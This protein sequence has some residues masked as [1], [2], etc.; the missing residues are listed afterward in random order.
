VIILV[1]AMLIAVP[2]FGTTTYLDDNTSYEVGLDIMSS[3]TPGTESFNQ[4]FK[5]F[6]ENQA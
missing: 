1:L 4:M 3:L 5:S 6:I 2:V